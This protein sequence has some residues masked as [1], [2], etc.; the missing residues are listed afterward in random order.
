MKEAASVGGLFHF[1]NGY[2]ATR[3]LRS[4]TFRPNTLSQRIHQVNPQRLPSSIPSARNGLSVVHYL[5]NIEV[6]S[7]GH[8]RHGRNEAKYAN[9]PARKWR[10]QRSSLV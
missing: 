8:K 9:D 5:P 10:V 6:A 3:R 2:L 1:R 4:T 7:W